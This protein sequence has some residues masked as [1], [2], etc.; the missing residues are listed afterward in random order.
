M[1][2]TRRAQSHPT[3]QL[4][5]RSDRRIESMCPRCW[6]PPRRFH[7]VENPALQRAADR[8]LGHWHTLERD[9]VERRDDLRNAA[10]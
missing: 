2:V 10:R 8:Y 5:F 6:G 3:A 1:I 9:V 7:L 4:P